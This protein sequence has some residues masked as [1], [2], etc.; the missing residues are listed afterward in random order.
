MSKKSVGAY[1]ANP[2]TKKLR[3]K[4]GM[5]QQ[6]IE[7]ARNARRQGSEPADIAK[8]MGQPIEQIN[9]ALANLRTGVANPDRKT[10]NVSPELHAHVMANR[11]Q[12]E[13]I[14]QTMD[15]LFLGKSK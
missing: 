5:S 11:K 7:D 9:L 1:E 15:R 10:L 3:P 8:Q 12:G 6:Q 4:I 2:N 14:K 13:S